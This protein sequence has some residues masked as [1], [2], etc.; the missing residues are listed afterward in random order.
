MVLATH[1]MNLVN[2]VPLDRIV[3]FELDRAC[4]KSAPRSIQAEPGA[5]VAELNR[6]GNSLG[7]ENAVLFYERCFFLFEGETEGNALPRLYEV[8]TGSKWY[9][10]GVRFANG[11]NN[12]GAVLFA[13]FLHSNGRPVV[14]LIDED[15]TRNKGFQRQF[16]RGRLEGQALLPPDR[17]KTIGPFCFELAFS[18]T[19]WYRAIHR[20][21]GRKKHL[22]KAKLDALRHSPKDFIRYLQTTSGDLSKVQLG[23]ALSSVTNK[24]E[25]PE[26]LGEAFEAARQYAADR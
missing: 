22:N 15:T 13:R 20:A 16:S 14:A 8:W 17:I 6:I 5:E 1:S 7:I 24:N 18:S 12:E 10:D 11:C 2:R 23:V 21:T 26:Q 3:H 9:L 19:V 4:G 25:I